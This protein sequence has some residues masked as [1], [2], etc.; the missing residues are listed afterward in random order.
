MAATIFSC[1]N[2][3]TLD[4]VLARL[5]RRPAVDGLLQIGS[6][7]GPALTPAS[8]YDLVVILNEMPAPLHVALTTID[9]RLTDVIFFQTAALQRILDHDTLADPLDALAGKLIR[10]LQTGQVVFDRA[11]RLAEAQRK[12]QAGAWLRPAGDGEI[13]AAWFS[14]NYNVQQTRRM[15]ASPDPVYQR[16]VDFRLLYQLAD[17]WTS[18]FRVRRLPW[19]GEKAAIRYLQANDPAYFDLFCACLAEADRTRKV[20]ICEQLAA[21][22]LAPAGGLWPAGATAIQLE[23]GPD[24]ELSPDA[25]PTALAFWES[26]VAG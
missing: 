6:T 13:Y 2:F 16:A 5:A 3:L 19:E 1:S 15:L 9:G 25:A 26:L 21:L 10:W 4:E 18:Y 11:G 8:D 22:T 14:V 7:G 23:L 12:V 24:G 20:Q 17:L